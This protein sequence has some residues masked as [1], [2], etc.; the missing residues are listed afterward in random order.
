M[1]TLSTP[2]RVLVPYGVAVLSLLLTVFSAL[3]LP[4]RIHDPTCM[5]DCF[6]QLNAVK[7]VM[8]LLGLLV[9]FIGIL[10]GAF[11]SYLAQS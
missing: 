7:V 9:A 3:V 5:L 8:I 2:R 4:T 10:V 6:P 1:A 11:R